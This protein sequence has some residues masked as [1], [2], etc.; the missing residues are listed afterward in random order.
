MKLLPGSA[1]SDQTLL[2]P[3]IPA[4]VVCVIPWWS[5]STGA[6]PE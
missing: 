3:G 5:D 1:G 2:L 4:I 6:G